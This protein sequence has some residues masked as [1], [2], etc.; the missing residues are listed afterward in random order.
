MT[1]SIH[2]STSNQYLVWIMMKRFISSQIG[3][4]KCTDT[5]YRF[6]SGHCSMCEAYHCVIASAQYAQDFVFLSSKICCVRC[7]TFNLAIALPT[8]PC[9]MTTSKRGCCM[10]LGECPLP[11]SG[12]RTIRMLLTW[13]RLWQILW[14]SPTWLTWTRLQSLLCGD[15]LTSLHCWMPTWLDNGNAWWRTMQGH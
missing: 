12:H 11:P 7:R 9:C 14:P 13:S 3:F 8:T 10:D 15:K 2:Q 4:A 1:S 5:A 6:Y